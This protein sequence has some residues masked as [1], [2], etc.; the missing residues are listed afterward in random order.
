M[1]TAGS[2]IYHYY[3]RDNNF[4]GKD[5]EDFVNHSQA[6]TKQHIKAQEQDCDTEGYPDEDEYDRG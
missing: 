4:Y 6:K 1:C 3:Y 5:D 2:V